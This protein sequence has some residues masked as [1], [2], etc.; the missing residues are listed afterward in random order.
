MTA[1]QVKVRV[2]KA[3]ELCNGVARGSLQHTT[4]QEPTRVVVLCRDA[5][6]CDERVANAKIDIRSTWIF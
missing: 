4:L 2:S 1:V 5:E 3:C 6:A